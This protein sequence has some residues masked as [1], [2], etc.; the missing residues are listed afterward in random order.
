M[1]SRVRKLNPLLRLAAIS[2]VETAIKLHIRRG[3]EV[4]LLIGQILGPGQR[5]FDQLDPGQMRV[6]LPEP[7]RPGILKQGAL[8][9]QG[10]AALPPVQMLD[11]DTGILTPAR[12]NQRALR[13]ADIVGQHMVAQQRIQD[14]GFSRA[15]LAADHDPGR[16]RGAVCFAR[17][18]DKGAHVSHF[19]AATLISDRRNA[20]SRDARLFMRFS[21]VSSA[22]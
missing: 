18:R 19:H 6:I 17:L 20:V 14:G 2:G 7:H 1:D 21:S 5:Q 8:A 13:L 22:A 9:R 10:G 3:D 11:L 16:C 12:N 15:D 4:D